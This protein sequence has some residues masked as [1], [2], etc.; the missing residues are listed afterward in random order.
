MGPVKTV[1]VPILPKVISEFGVFPIRNSKFVMKQ[2]NPVIHL[3][4]KMA[5]ICQENFKKDK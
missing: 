5:K 3:E 2:A 1:N 4:N